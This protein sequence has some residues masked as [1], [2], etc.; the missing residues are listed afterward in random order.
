[1]TTADIHALTGAYAVDAVPGAERAAFE[2]HLSECE[3]CAQEV[4]ELRETATRL[5]LAAAEDPPPALKARVLDQIKTVRQE[6][7]SATVTPLR[8]RDRRAIALRLTSVAAAVLLAAA[9]ALGV[10]VVRQNDELDQTR[11]RA[12]EMSEI[13]RAGDAQVLT[14]DKGKDGRM[15]VAMS[16][17][18]NRM[19]L[20]T[21]DLPNPP[22]GKDLQVW[23]G[24]GGTMVSA[25][26]LTPDNGDAVLEIS[27]FGDADAI[28]VTLEPDGGSDSP[29]LPAVMEVPLPA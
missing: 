3:S 15:T 24:H 9:V 20:L 6:S 18:E 11:A 17:S 10:L 5:A 2:R 8:H 16:R 7:P 14:V 26:F 4:R 19:L 21:D 27:G 25:G 22:E 13:L 12:A 23:T 28:G 1:M 29:T